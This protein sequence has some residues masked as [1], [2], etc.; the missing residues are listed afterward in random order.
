[1]LR[2]TIEVMV[3]RGT[4]DLSVLLN[5]ISNRR[6]IFVGSRRQNPTFAARCSDRLQ[7]AARGR[8]RRCVVRVHPRGAPIIAGEQVGGEIGARFARCSS[9]PENSILNFEIIVHA[10][11]MFSRGALAES[12]SMISLLNLLGGIRRRRIIWASFS[13]R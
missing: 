7:M 10:S 6:N 13:A 3:L 8:T 11:V 5:S 1:M 4:I 2:G 9:S 12:W